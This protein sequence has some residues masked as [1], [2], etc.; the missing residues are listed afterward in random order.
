MKFKRKV[1]RTLYYS[2]GMNREGEVIGR[3]VFIAPTWE[4]LIP[5]KSPEKQPILTASHRSMETGKLQDTKIL[6]RVLLTNKI[7]I[8][9]FP[10]CRTPFLLLK[11]E[12]IWGTA[13]WLGVWSQSGPGSWVTSR[14][15]KPAPQ[16]GV[17]CPCC[18]PWEPEQPVPKFSEHCRR[19]VK[20]I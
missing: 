3:T 8:W 10:P 17:S 2:P 16:L 11:K 12:Y 18:S 1:S 13:L 15:V 7:L 5:F 20:C 14:A 9:V 19:T 4:P 6:N